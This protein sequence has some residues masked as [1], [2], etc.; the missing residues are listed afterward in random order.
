MTETASTSSSRCTRRRDSAGG[1]LEHQERHCDFAMTCSSRNYRAYGLHIRSPI[2]LP[3]ALL[4]GPPTGEPDVTIRLGTT[5]VA[6]PNS[7]E[8]RRLKP[9]MNGNL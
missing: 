7:I 8:R 2:D 1:V 4:F 3:F 5:P 9:V 6:I